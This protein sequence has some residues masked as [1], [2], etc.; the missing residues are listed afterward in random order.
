MASS[1]STLSPTGGVPEGVAGAVADGVA[2]RRLSKSIKY[3]ASPERH[4]DSMS[5]A[6][7]L[8]VNVVHRLRPGYFHDTAID[9]RPVDGPVQVN[10]LGL[11]GDQK[12]DSSHGG[13]DKAVYAYSIED[14]DWW[15]AQLGR[16]TPPGLFGENLRTCGVETS[17]ALIGERWRIGPTLLEVRMPRTPC[18]NLSLRMGIEKFHLRFNRTGRVGAMLKVLEPGTV[19]AG[20]PIRLEYRPEHGVRVADLATGPDADQMQRLLDSGVPLA[21]NVRAKARRI[22][23]RAALASA[24]AS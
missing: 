24:P 16:E 5:A 20:D 4:A 21:K 12:I 9:K 14:A 1:R 11:A 18:D 19:R 8:T 2:E 7:V 10:E 15:A 17:D 22:V 23:R 13:P 6:R 3:D